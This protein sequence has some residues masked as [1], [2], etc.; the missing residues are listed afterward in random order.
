MSTS[1]TFF[2]PDFRQ[3]PSRQSTTVVGTPTFV[4]VS[5]W[6]A[7]YKNLYGIR[8]TTK[9]GTALSTRYYCQVFYSNAGNIP[10]PNATDPLTPAALDSEDTAFFQKVNPSNTILIRVWKEGGASWVA[11]DE[12][13]VYLYHDPIEC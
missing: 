12:V 2:S 4:D 11:A 10:L 9:N 5:G 1:T 8:I 3:A 13:N 7:G 6:Q